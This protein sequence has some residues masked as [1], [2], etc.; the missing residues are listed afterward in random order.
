MVYYVYIMTN[1][2]NGTLYVGVT[3]DLVKRATQHREGLLRGFTR[4]HRLHT[5]VYFESTADVR[6]AIQREKLLKKWRRAWKIELI[7]RDNP[8]WDDLYLAIQGALAE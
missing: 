3:D 8:M 6:A 4:T 1:R 7:E 5:L 2:R